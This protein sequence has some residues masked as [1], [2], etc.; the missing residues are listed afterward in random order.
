MYR[1]AKDLEDTFPYSFSPTHTGTGTSANDIPMEGLDSTPPC[2]A[3]LFLPF[4]DC[5]QTNCANATEYEALAGCIV[6]NCVAELT[7][8]PQECWTCFASSGTDLAAMV[9][10]CVLYLLCIG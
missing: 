5:L 2:P 10:R 6:P 9:E 1:I 4:A 7:A 8:L 3:A